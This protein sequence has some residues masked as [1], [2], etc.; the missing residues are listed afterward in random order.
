[1]CICRSRQA[2]V[3]KGISRRPGSRVVYMCA[4]HPK[5]FRKSP[6]TCAGKYWSPLNQ[7]SKGSSVDAFTLWKNWMLPKSSLCACSTTGV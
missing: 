4:K 5:R 3:N 6:R 7:D 1:M 2:V